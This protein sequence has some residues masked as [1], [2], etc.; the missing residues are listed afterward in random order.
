METSLRCADCAEIQVA[1]M[2]DGDTLDTSRGRIR[3]FGVHTLERGERH[4]SE[5]TDQPNELAVDA[6]R[7][8]DGPRLSD[9]FGR[10]LTYVYTADGISID[11]TQIREGLATAKT[12]DGQHRDF[13]V[14]LERD[15]RERVASGNYDLRNEPSGPGNETQK[16]FCG[17][18]RQTEGPDHSIPGFF[19]PKC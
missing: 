3:L 5:A 12:Q 17:H 2:I 19:V 15:A 18:H 4:G 6:V 8:E 7:L 13:L 16:K 14:E 9:R 11:E 10:I 1:R